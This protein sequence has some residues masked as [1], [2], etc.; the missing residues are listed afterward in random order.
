MPHAPSQPRAKAET[1]QTLWRDIAFHGCYRHTC[2]GTRKDNHV[3]PTDL[4]R[5]LLRC[6]EATSRDVHA[7]L[8]N[9]LEHNAVHPMLISDILGHHPNWNLF[10]RLLGCGIRV[11]H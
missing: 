9:G 11:C 5:A 6:V 2:S 1:G 7:T 8:L 10:E 4:L 3:A